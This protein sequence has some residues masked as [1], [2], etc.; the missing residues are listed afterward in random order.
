[1]LNGRNYSR[2]AAMEAS[3]AVPDAIAFTLLPPAV[4]RLFIHIA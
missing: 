1:M 4:C 2:S 3:M